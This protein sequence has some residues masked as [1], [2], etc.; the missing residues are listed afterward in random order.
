MTRW[1][2]DR[3][4]SVSEGGWWRRRGWDF[5]TAFVSTAGQGI[6]KKVGEGTMAFYSRRTWAG[7]IPGGAKGQS[8]HAK[9]SQAGAM[10]KNRAKQQLDSKTTEKHTTT[11]KFRVTASD[12]L[13][14]DRPSS[15]SPA[16]G[17]GGRGRV[18]RERKQKKAMK[19][20]VKK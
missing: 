16:R 17:G 13:S 7:V 15:S 4:G 3:R 9:P 8:G 2:G 5:L 6:L 1:S 18:G 10:R 20:K 19:N 12:W 11:Q 14:P